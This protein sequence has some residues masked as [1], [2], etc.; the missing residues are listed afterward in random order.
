MKDPDMR[1]SAQ[2]CIPY[3]NMFQAGFIVAADERDFAEILEACSMPSILA[4]T[5]ERDILTAFISGTLDQWKTAVLRACV[6]TARREVRHTFNLV[7]GEFNKVGLASLFE[8]KKT[9]GQDQTFYLE[10]NG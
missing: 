1:P 7:Y 8:A 2:A 5:I 4:E 6:K 3:M 10:Y 9:Y